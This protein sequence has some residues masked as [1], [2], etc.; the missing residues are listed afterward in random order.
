MGSMGNVPKQPR[1]PDTWGVAGSAH[2]GSLKTGLGRPTGVGTGGGRIG[3]GASGWGLGG[4]HWGGLGVLPGG[5]AGVGS[6]R[7]PWSGRLLS[8]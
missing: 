8:V 6:G 7:T 5:G 4:A 1:G 3:V 2:R